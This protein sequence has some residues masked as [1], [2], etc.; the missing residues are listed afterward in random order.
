[1]IEFEDHLSAMPV[2]KAANSVRRPVSRRAVLIG[3]LPVLAAA[4]GAAG[5]LAMQ[6]ARTARAPAPRMAT[7]QSVFTDAAT[8]A[9]ASSTPIVASVPATPS[10]SPYRRALE[11]SGLPE[12]MALAVSPRMPVSAVGPDDPWRMLTGDVSDWSAVGAAMPFPIRPVALADFVVSGIQ[13]AEIFQSYDALAVGLVAD[14]GA[15]ALL[16]LEV[17]DYRVQ[18]LTVGGTDPL[19]SPVSGTSPVRIGVVGDIV[20]GRNVHLHM[21]EYGDFTRPF[22]R[23]APLLRS[24]DLTL[25]N[26]EGNLSDTLPQPADPHS[27]SFVSSPVMLEG[28]AHAGIDAV[29]LANNHSVWNDEGWGVQGLLDTIA[30]LDRYRVPYLGAGV[31]IARA[32]TPAV[33]DVGGTTIAFLGVDA[34]T[35][36]YDVEPGVA[37]GVLDT[38]VGATADRA[39]TNPYI[40]SQVF[41]DVA[42]ATAVAEVV[43]P[44]FHLGAEYVA[45][46]PPWA[47]E[48]AHL[49]ID[50]GAAMVV[51]NHPH[52]IQGMEIYAGK[53]I[54]YSPGNFILDQMWAAEVRSGYALEIVLRGSAV[55]GLRFHGVEI[56]DFHQPRLMS[57]GEQA[58]LMDRF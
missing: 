55:V 43:I 16:P 33:F 34:V 25:A 49:A 41:A 29:T 18:T 39:G 42:A 6:M 23:V 44:Y 2:L 13:Y 56:E 40:G 10:V 11:N 4:I 32:R 24:F 48:A 8:S 54:V 27:V 9:T 46:P 30:A 47:V 21:L 37:N 58:A 12:G 26:L 38:D 20:P 1:M 52:L 31:D 7:T 57:S 22:R 15:I 3:A 45:V 51:T 36:N 35:A 53:P 17:V 5:A 28:F 50:A 14:P 19:R